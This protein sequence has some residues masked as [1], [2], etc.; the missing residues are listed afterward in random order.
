MSD[1][2]VRVASGRKITA[3]RHR[4]IVLLAALGAHGSAWASGALVTA[5]DVAL[6]MILAGLYAS[7]VVASIVVTF[8][9]WRA[10]AG[11]AALWYL[12]VP[13]EALVIGLILLSMTGSI[14]GELGGGDGTTNAFA[15]GI[16]LLAWALSHG[17]HHE[18]RPTVDGA[19]AERRP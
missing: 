7:I 8:R 14:V 1:G 5:D 2:I 17:L 13:V 6:V 4:G 19:G 11:R 3:S 10:G 12:L 15:A 16:V 18:G 9:R